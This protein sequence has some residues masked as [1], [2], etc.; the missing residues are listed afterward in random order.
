[1]EK[2]TKDMMEKTRASAV[3]ILGFFKIFPVKCHSINI[4]LCIHVM[5]NIAPKALRIGYLAKL[6]NPWAPSRMNTVPGKTHQLKRS[7]S[8]M[9][10]RTTNSSGVEYKCNI[11]GYHQDSFA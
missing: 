11:F 5:V 9:V 4:D 8:V 6:R 2:S 1:M 7:T 10:E 3:F